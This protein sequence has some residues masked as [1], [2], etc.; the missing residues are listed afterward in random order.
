[1]IVACET[2][3]GIFSQK[4]YDVEIIHDGVQSGTSGDYVNM[5]FTLIH[6]EIPASNQEQQNQGNE[7]N[8]G[9]AGDP[10]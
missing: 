5:T 6:E 2:L 9:I 3:F 10:D 7:Q 4:S 1:M 8:A